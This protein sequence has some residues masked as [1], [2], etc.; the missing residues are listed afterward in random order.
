MRNGERQDR[1]IERSQA[2]NLGPFPFLMRLCGLEENGIVL[3]FDVERL[4]VPCKVYKQNNT[5]MD[6]HCIKFP[7]ESIWGCVS[8]GR[9]IPRAWGGDT[10]IIQG[11]DM[12]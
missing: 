11:R 4:R 12:N 7:Q 9:E 2:Q 10:A 5:M 6:N 3:E 8:G 1:K